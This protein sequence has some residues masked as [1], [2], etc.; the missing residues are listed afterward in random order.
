MHAAVAPAS[1][2]PR[3]TWTGLVA[4]LVWGASVGMM[5]SITEAFG[6]VAGGAAVFTLSGVLAW[7]VV[8]VPPL[9]ALHPA[10]LWLAGAL[11]V[12][13]EICF[14]L[15]LGLAH[16]RAQA[17]ELGMLNYLWPSLTILL[18]VL[19]RQQRGSPLLLPGVAL[20]LVGVVLVMGN[21]HWSPTLLWHNV[22]GNP[23]AY[24]M[25]ASAAVLWACYS[26]LTRLY[27]N[28]QSA[29]PLFLLATGVLLW[30]RYATSPQPPMALS[31]ASIAQVLVQ[32]CFA[33][34]S[35]SCW[36]LGIQRGN[37]TLLAAASYLTPVLSVLLG[38]AWLGVVPS[39]AF[40]QGVVLVCAGSLLCWWSTRR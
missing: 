22:L 17:L 9:R 10:Y 7:R 3:A 24:A 30:G 18:A 8:G 40:W 23:L 21:G 5:R 39:M 20:S 15:S 38:S 25:A 19:C 13:Y 27:G 29:V 37:M 2:S 31:F 35:F 14:A 1:S 4:I 34:A 11:F 28:G 33:A 12:V 32:G 26:L 36:N 16:D 6:P